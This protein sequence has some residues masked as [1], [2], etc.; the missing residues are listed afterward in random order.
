L[1]LKMDN[2]VLNILREMLKGKDKPAL[3]L[4]VKGFTWKGPV[5]GMVPDEKREND[6]EFSVKDVD[7]VVERDYEYLFNNA[8]ISYKKSAFGGKFEIMPEEIDL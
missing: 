8:T 6:K 7:F 4:L 5:L 3:R 1:I 2:N